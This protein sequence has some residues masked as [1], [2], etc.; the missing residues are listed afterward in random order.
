VGAWLAIGAAYDAVFGVGIL[1]FTRPLASL[2]GLDVPAD[3][4]YL[5]LNGVLLLLLAGLYAAAAG[6][7]E[8]YRAI[9]PIASAGRAAGC[10]LFLT[11]WRGGRPVAF[12]VLG[13]LDLT[14]GVAQL[15][16]WRRAVAL[17]D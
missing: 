14:L 10:L 9:P 5:H 8:R 6:Q 4:F 1:A 2:L 13:L 15:L 12:L 7:P 16:A 3:P 11:A 17:S